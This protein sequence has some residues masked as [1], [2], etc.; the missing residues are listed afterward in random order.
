MDLL[1]E[2]AGNIDLCTREPWI[3]ED[4]EVES[5][6]MLDGSLRT[7]NLKEPGRV[8]IQVICRA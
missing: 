7:W 4:V 6:A 1:R 5:G 8:G 3:D 2:P